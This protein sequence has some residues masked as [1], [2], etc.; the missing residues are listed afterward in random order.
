MRPGGASPPHPAEVRELNGTA[1]LFR[2]IK[3]VGPTGFGPFDTPNSQF[4]FLKKHSVKTATTRIGKE[5]LNRSVGPN[6]NPT[7]FSSKPH[8]RRFCFFGLKVSLSSSKNLRLKKL[9]LPL[10]TT[11]AS[12][13][14][15]SRSVLWPSRRRLS[16]LCLAS[17]RPSV[18]DLGLYK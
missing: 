17:A 4:K 6:R 10:P 11:A 13:Y 7:G 8:T 15:P 2:R 18:E 1:R 9:A 3:R 14:P 5:L 16:R 12:S